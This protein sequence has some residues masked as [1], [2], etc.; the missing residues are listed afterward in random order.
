MLKT[1]TASDSSGQGTT[2]V[3]RKRTHEKKKNSIDQ[4]A[5]QFGSCPHQL[6]TN[7]R[8]CCKSET[9]YHPEKPGSSRQWK[10]K[11]LKNAREVENLAARPAGKVARKPNSSRCA[12]SVVTLQR[13]GVYHRSPRRILCNDF[14]C[15]PNFVRFADVIT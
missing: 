10:R 15:G 9:E 6:T 8:K 3:P 11:F 2:V 12:N 1:S 14:D 7:N 4:R 13:S 5:R